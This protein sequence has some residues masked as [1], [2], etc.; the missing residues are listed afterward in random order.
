MKRYFTILIIIFI[1][2]L[3]TGCRKVNN[4]IKITIPS[5]TPLIAVGGVLDDVNYN[6]VIGS[7]LLITAFTSKD[8]DIVIAP[9][10]TGA[11]LFI[12]QGTKFKLDSIITFGNTYI[13]SKQDKQLE[14]IN[15]LEGKTI[16]AYGNN[17]TP[18]II[19]NKVLDKYNISSDIKYYPSITDL[20]GP[21]INGVYDYILTAEPTLTNIESTIPNLNIINLQELIVE[22][23][24]LDFLPQ[25]AI[26]VNPN[27]N[28]KKIEDFIN[29]INL[30]IEYLNLN[31]E[32]YANEIYNTNEYFIK[33]K[34]DII[35][36]S[37]ARSNISFIKAK[38][39]I[40]QIE[41][42]FKMINKYN[43]NILS[44]TLPNH[45]FYN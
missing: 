5:G 12:N 22:N 26:F 29:K 38:D 35:G 27:S 8:I 33:M 1:I 14:S 39:K 20:V 3:F 40:S 36:K 11:K 42:F 15:D 30:N 9:I 43:P 41:E 10:T 31:P 44:N 25:A 19:L 32:S 18:S 13:V 2:A 34:K 4:K 6:V 21:F 45:D 24:N 28:N 23:S 16:G 17:A 7:E 37:I